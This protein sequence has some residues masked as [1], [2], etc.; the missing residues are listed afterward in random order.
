L[1]ELAQA[2]ATV[3]MKKAESW[4]S[5]HH[6]KEKTWR[7]RTAA[8][9]KQLQQTERSRNL[10]RR[11]WN[12]TGPDQLPGISLV[13]APDQAGTWKECTKKKDIEDGCI[14]Y[15]NKR[16]RQTED[17]PF[18]L[19]SQ[20]VLDGTYKSLCP[21]NPH[22]ARL[23][24]GLKTVPGCKDKPL[25]TGIRTNNFVKGW[26]KA[27]ERTSAGP[28]NIHFGHC[29]T[30]ARDSL[31]ATF[32]AAMASIPMKS[33]YAYKRWRK[34]IDVELLKKT[35]SF[36]VDKLQTIVLFEADFNFTNKCI[37]NKVATRA[38]ATQGLAE[39]QFGSR[40]Q[41]RTIELSHYGP[42]LTRKTARRSLL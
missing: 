20:A 37:S 31:I 34:V 9:I 3:K 40:K 30:M 8:D 23:L 10:A 24:Q 42:P 32:E 12:A 29:K 14:W 21:I 27:K 1:R 22:A 39:E 35:N 18:M 36:R 19:Q 26:S 16:F 2:R 28:S 6:R 4:S 38:E 15:T 17:T 5:V 11:I 13:I 33:G 25:Q 7:Q 41:H